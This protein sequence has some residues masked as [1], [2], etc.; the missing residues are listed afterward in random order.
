VQLSNNWNYWKKTPTQICHQVD[1]P[2][3]QP[4]T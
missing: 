2:Q 3:L 1:L 4:I